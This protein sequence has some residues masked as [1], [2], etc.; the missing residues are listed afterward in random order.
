MQPAKYELYRLYFKKERAIYLNLNKCILRGNF[1]DGE[2]WIPEDKFQYVQDALQNVSRD[3]FT[4]LTANFSDSIETE[5]M[6][7]PTYLKTNDLSAPFQQIVDTYGIPRY[8]EVNPGIF[9][10][11]TFPFLFGVMFGDIGHGLLLFLFGLYLVLQHDEIIKSGSAL[12]PALK[13]RY[14]LLFM[15]FFAFYCGW[16]YNDFL[17]LPLGIFGTCYKNEEVNGEEVGV[18]ISESCVYPFGL[19]PKWYVA[20][21]ELAFFNSMKMKLSVIL[22]VLQMLFGIVLKGVNAVYF[23]NSVD[24]IFEFIP[25]II[26]MSILFGYMIVMIICKWLTHWDDTSKAPSIISLLMSIFLKGGS[27]GDEVYIIININ[28]RMIKSQFG[29]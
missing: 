14:L 1:I 2:V 6:V 27:V 13:A 19:D 10:I 16:M 26:F 4:K 18:R 12:K 28:F 3:N 22:G 15:G 11:V 21:N 7:P 9:A 24:F 23:R 25:Q 29:V 20:K 8:R 17:S 5:N